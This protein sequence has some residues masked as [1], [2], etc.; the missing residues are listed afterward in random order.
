MR[1]PWS[2]DID[3]L[4][5]GFVDRRQ[6]ANAQSAEG[7]PEWHPTYGDGGPAVAAGVDVAEVGAIESISDAEEQDDVTRPALQTFAA[8]RSSPTASKKRFV[9]KPHTR[10]MSILGNDRTLVLYSSTALL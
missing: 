2:L 10:A 6:I 8:S 9:P 5:E 7:D 3:H 4:A 1:Q